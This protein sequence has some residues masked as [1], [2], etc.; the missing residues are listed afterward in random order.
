MFQQS[1]DGRDFLKHAEGLELEAY[2][3]P[4]GQTKI[5]SIGYG[6]RSKQGERITVA[7]AEQLLREDVAKVVA[8]LNGAI[9]FPTTQPQFD[10][11]VSLAYNVGIGDDGTKPGISDPDDSGVLGSTLLRKHNAGDWLGAADEFP[12]WRNAG[13]KPSPVLE[14]R[15]KLERGIYL[16]PNVPLMQPGDGGVLLPAGSEP[17]IAGGVGMLF[18]CPYCSRKCAARCSVEKAGDS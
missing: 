14:A 13:G 7:Q 12:K 1:E 4:P 10:A 3:D 9:H 2:P 17:A 18:F 8:A 6:H 5:W 16:T 11:L 15:R